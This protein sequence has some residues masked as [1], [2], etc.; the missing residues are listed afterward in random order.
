VAAYLLGTPKHYSVI[1]AGVT[2]ILNGGNPPS[3]G[4]AFVQ[5]FREYMESLAYARCGSGAVFGW[6]GAQGVG[7]LGP[8]T[9]YNGE[10]PLNNQGVPVLRKPNGIEDI[11]V[12]NAFT[13]RLE[14]ETNK[15]TLWTSSSG[16]WTAFWVQMLNDTQVDEYL[17]DPAVS[18][19]SPLYLSLLLE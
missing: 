3:A 7:S 1:T 17:L 18:D 10:V 2:R 6:G 16:N 4:I 9:I 14:A 12:I 13:A 15:S 19:L 5:A 8:P 11:E